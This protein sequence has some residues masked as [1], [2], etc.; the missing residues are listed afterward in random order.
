MKKIC[1]IALL[2]SLICSLLFSTGCSNETPQGFCTAEDVPEITDDMTYDEMAK[3]AESSRLTKKQQYIYDKTNFEKNKEKYFT[4]RF[5]IHFNY[6]ASTEYAYE[7]RD[8]LMYNERA[9]GKINTT[10][11]PDFI[12]VYLITN[13]TE[14]LD[15]IMRRFISDSRVSHVSFVEKNSNPTADETDDVTRK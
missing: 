1:T 6:D 4:D 14:K 13:D 9:I 15:R 12:T 11:L 3:K 7:I 5:T 2:T 10:N 8:N